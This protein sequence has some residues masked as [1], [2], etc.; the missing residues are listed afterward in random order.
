MKSVRSQGGL[1]ARVIGKVL[2]WR[3][4][5]AS[6]GLPDVFDCKQPALMSSQARPSRHE[7]QRAFPAFPGYASPQAL[8]PRDSSHW[9]AQAFQEDE[10][11]ANVL[12]HTGR[13]FRAYG[14]HPIDQQ[15]SGR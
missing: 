10:R 9:N 15:V 13:A 4:Q 11:R 14:G 2:V 8:L 3:S 7:A 6:L 12:L 1:A 5:I